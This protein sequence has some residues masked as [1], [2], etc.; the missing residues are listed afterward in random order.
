MQ[1]LQAQSRRRKA[2]SAL[3]PELLQRLAKKNATL[4]INTRN[5]R[6]AHQI[7]PAH[8]PLRTPERAGNFAGVHAFANSAF[9]G[10]VPHHPPAHKA[11]LVACHGI[12]AMRQHHKLASAT[13]P[14]LK[15]LHY[16]I[17]PKL[18]KP[19]LVKEANRSQIRPYLVLRR[20]GK[21]HK[22]FISR[23]IAT[24]FIPNPHNYKCVRHL[25]DISTDNKLSNIAWGSN[26]TNVK[27]R[28]FNKNNDIKIELLQ[29][30]LNK[31]KELYGEI[32]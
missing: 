31:Y 19:Q 15:R 14:S 9:D 27:D 6:A 26:F 16:T 8:R 32:N 1:A 20:E 13:G 28:E 23:L 3:S 30:Q 25:N 29:E 11:R 17:T 10:V 24:T 5:A 22:I 18:L 21:R 12:K 4:W 2:R 7:H